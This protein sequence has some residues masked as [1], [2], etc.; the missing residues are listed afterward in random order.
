MTEPKADTGRRGLHSRQR[1][2]NPPQEGLPASGGPDPQ[3]F[4]RPRSLLTNMSHCGKLKRTD[5]LFEGISV[6]DIPCAF[7]IE[8]E[9]FVKE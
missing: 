5:A 1:R 8:L 3:A 7:L 2:A 4:S 9:T 6:E